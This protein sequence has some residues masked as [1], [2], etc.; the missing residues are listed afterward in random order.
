[1]CCKVLCVF[2]SDFFLM[3]DFLTAF[4]YPAQ[5]KMLCVHGFKYRVNFHLPIRKAESCE[6]KLAYCILY[7]FALQHVVKAGMKCVVPNSTLWE[8]VCLD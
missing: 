4:S 7:Y 6:Y 2:L 5:S 8:P 3:V 1:M